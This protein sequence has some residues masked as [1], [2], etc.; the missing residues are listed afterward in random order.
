M[1][2]RLGEGSKEKFLVELPQPLTSPANKCQ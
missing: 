2:E 1:G